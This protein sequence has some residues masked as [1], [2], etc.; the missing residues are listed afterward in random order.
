MAELVLVYGKSG[1]GKSR[2]LVNFG[3]DEILLFNVEGKRL[4]TR[5]KFKYVSATTSVDTIKKGLLKMPENNLK[6]AVIDDAGYLMTDAFMAGHGKGDQ[7]KLFNDI[8]DSFWGMLTAIKK[9]LPDNIIVYVMMHEQMSDNYG[10]VKLRTIGKLLDD[11][12]CIEGMATVVLRAVKKPEG[13]FFL[14]QSTGADI[15]KSPE[16][17]FNAEEPNDLKAID[18]KIRDYWGL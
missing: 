16:G 8:A 4:P 2:S 9:D 18:T 1:T 5:K 15:S 17:M 3:E 13:Y 10:E 6:T 11:K 12:V 7:F 14:T